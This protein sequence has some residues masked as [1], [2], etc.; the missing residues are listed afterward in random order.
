MQ[1]PLEATLVF[2]PSQVTC[3]SQSTMLLP[4]RAT[5]RTQPRSI[6]PPSLAAAHCGHQTTMTA[7]P[8]SWLTGVVNISAFRREAHSQLGATLARRVRSRSQCRNG[9]RKIAWRWV[10]RRWV[11]RLCGAAPTRTGS[12][13][14]DAG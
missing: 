13:R 10:A 3:T 5:R 7:P 14:V 9:T 4:S 12:R 2:G 8:P 11:A 1:L 6:S